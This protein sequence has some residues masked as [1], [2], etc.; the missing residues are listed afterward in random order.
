MP[1]L[2]RGPRPLAP[3]AL[4]LTIF[5]ACGESS[6]SSD[7]S[8]VV[9]GPLTN[10]SG[11]SVPAN[12]RV[13]VAW[14]VTSADPDYTYIYGEGSVQAGTYRISFSAPPPAEALNAGQLGVGIVLLTS[15]DGLRSGMRLED[16]PANTVLL[17]GTGNYA[18]IYK[19][20]ETITRVDW[21]DPFPLGFGAGVG[22][23]QPG[24]FDAFAPTDPSGLE[25][26]VDDID[27]IDFVNWT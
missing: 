22:V 10:V 20:L 26:I 19:A 8:F 9:R 21:A 2:T 13:V 15:G 14:V 17:G 16:A 7:E 3:L 12:A 11:Q 27:N 1:T 6:G 24:D 25:L 18:V 23:E 4:A 5:A